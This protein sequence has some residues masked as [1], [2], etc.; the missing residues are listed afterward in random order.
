MC[1]CLCVCVCVCVCVCMCVCVCVCVCVCL[2]L[3]VCTCVCDYNP[4]VPGSAEESGCY[5]RRKEMGQ[6]WPLGHERGNYILGG[7]MK[8]MMPFFSFFFFNYY[9]FIH[10][11]SYVCFKPFFCQV[12][13]SESLPLA[14]V[15]LGLRGAWL[16]WGSKNVLKMLTFQQLTSQ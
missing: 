15:I 6:S 4:Y 9:I 13:L 7:L 8:E 12:I 2:C 14:Q 16:E 1:V 3:S 5:I 11:F 10:T